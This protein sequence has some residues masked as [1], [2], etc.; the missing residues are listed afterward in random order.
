MAK[1]KLECPPCEQGAPQW[2]TTYSDMVTLLLCLFIMIY[3]TGKAPPQEIQLILSAFN[4][5]LGF[6]TG[7]QTLS[8]G[9]MEEMGMNL[10]SLPSETPGRSLSKAKKQA[11]TIFKP[12]I[13]AKLVRVTEDERGLVISLIGADYFEPGSALLNADMEA[14][15]KKS[16]LLIRELD[17][18]VRVEGHAA[19]GEDEILTGRAATTRT[20]R[21]YLNSWDLAAARAIN[22]VVFLQSQR[23]APDLL[24]VVS[25]GSARPLAL[26]GDQG[27]PESAAH[28]RRIDIVIM[29]HKEQKRSAGESSFGLPESRLPQSEELVE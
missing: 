4:N 10:E 11:Q 12:E 6:F 8:K 18:F 14:I 29:P 5:S 17:K 22:A 15:L 25:F 1:K 19:R 7:G 27:T 28:N 20:E 2:M 24:Q 26:E 21:L 13:Q 9:R 23:V 16:A 3:A